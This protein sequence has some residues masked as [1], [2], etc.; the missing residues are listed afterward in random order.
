M[1]RLPSARLPHD[2]YDCDM[3]SPVR[4]CAGLGGESRWIWT[5]SSIFPPLSYMGDSFIVSAPRYRQSPTLC[6]RVSSTFHLSTVASRVPDES[7]YRTCSHSRLAAHESSAWVSLPP[8][9]KRVGTGRAPHGVLVG[10]GAV[11]C[12][13]W[14]LGLCELL[15]PQ[16]VTFAFSCSSNFPCFHLLSLFRFPTLRDVL[17][18]V[19]SRLYRTDGPPGLPPSPSQYPPSTVLTHS[20]TYRPPETPH[21][22]RPTPAHAEALLL[23]STFLR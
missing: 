22:T 7:R 17:K 4:R 6:A 9:R 8:N 1:L 21:A 15:R 11:V 2:D 23:G 16:F 13:A 19:C 14:S 5:S 18:S 20:P 10:N 12:D 3:G